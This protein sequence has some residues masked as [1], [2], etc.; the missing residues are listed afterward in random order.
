[1]TDALV[2]G[3]HQQALNLTDRSIH[4]GDGLFETI[5]VLDGQPALWDAHMRR[6]HSGCERLL[7]P[8]PDLLQLLEEATKLTAGQSRAV[9]K[10]IYSAGDS[11]RGYSRTDPVEPARIL[12]R[13]PAPEHPNAY[14]SAGVT[15]GYCA[16]RLM[17][18]GALA[19]IKHLNRLEQ[20]VARRE[21][22][23]RRLVEGLMLDQDG[24]VI[25]GV[26]SNLFAVFDGLMLTPP[27]VETGV[28]GIMRDHIVELA[29]RIGIRVEER[30]L[31]PMMLDE[32]DELLLTNSLIGLWPIA[33]LEGRHYPPGAVG[34]SILQVLQKA[35]S[36]LAPDIEIDA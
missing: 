23:G 13:L 6:L 28:R 29:G 33:S 36:C 4:Y 34:R 5:A 35:K 14:W 2:N 1:M 16:Q 11:A 24:Y 19:G 30:S 25:E 15:V 8:P 10:L 32:A 12:L 31:T 22:D 17:P 27:I 26:A 20:V 7:L 21:L 18:Q 9:L 3:R